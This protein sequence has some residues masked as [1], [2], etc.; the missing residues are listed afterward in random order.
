MLVNSVREVDVLSPAQ[1]EILDQNWSQNFV[2]ISVPIIYT[3]ALKSS[4]PE[5]LQ[6]YLRGEGKGISS[7]TVSISSHWCNY[8][9]FI[10]Y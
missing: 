8:F 4:L 2:F 5:N 3:R 6:I 10:S 9:W 1:S 7:S